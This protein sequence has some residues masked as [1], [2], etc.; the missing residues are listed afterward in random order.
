MYLLHHCRK[1]DLIGK[2]D[3]G[4]PAV[5]P[6]P[7]HCG[8][9]KVKNSYYRNVYISSRRESYHCSAV[10][11]NR[12]KAP[13]LCCEMSLLCSGRVRVADCPWWM[14]R[15][16]L[17]QRR[18]PSWSAGREQLCYPLPQIQR[19]IPERMLAA[20]GESL[21][22]C[23]KSIQFNGLAKLDFTFEWNVIGI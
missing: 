21:S 4:W 10:C 5:C 18:Q 12:L 14:E 22:R 20:G 23:C 1:S 8:L 6:P 3:L 19:S 13:P 15:A 11:F 7:Q 2:S 9:N 17:H 16:F